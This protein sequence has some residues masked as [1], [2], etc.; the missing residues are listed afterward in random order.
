MLNDSR[1]VFD[2]VHFVL[3]ADAGEI[4]AHLLT[5]LTSF[6]LTAILL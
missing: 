6:W 4:S 5:F 2:K 3:V 1:D